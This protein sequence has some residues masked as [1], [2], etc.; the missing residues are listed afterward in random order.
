MIYPN[1]CA[2]QARNG[3]NNTKMAALLGMKRTTYV[4]KKKSGHF[5]VDECKALCKLLN[6]EFDYLFFRPEADGDKPQN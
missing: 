6:C 1:L 2:E 4:M 3:L 5:F